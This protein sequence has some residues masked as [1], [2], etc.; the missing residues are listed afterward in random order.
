MLDQNTHP[1]ADFLHTPVDPTCASEVGDVAR[2]FNRELSW[3]EFDRRV[4]EE[5]QNPALPLLERLNFLAISGSN[6]DEFYSVR[7]AAL[8]GLARQGVESLSADG[9]TPRAQL[10]MI[11]VLALEV[12]ATQQRVWKDMVAE[13][14]GQRIEVLNA[15]ALRK[16]E[17]GAI[18]TAF[19]EQI[20][21]VVTPIA[22]DPAHPFPFIPNGEF[23]LALQDA[24][25]VSA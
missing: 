11:R 17:I 13:L 25:F 6:L 22:I 15:D 16:K 5:A 2:Y 24:H 21:P 3:L 18:E 8:Q 14:H 12:Q 10:E 1:N 7:V 23:A 19:M 4:L 20:F 9:L